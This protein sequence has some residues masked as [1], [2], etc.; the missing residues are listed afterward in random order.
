MDKP[1]TAPATPKG[2]VDPLGMARRIRL[3]T[4]PPSAPLARF[5]DYVWIVEWNMGER[6]PEIQRVLPYPNAHLVFDHGRTAIHGV[7]R[8]AFERKVAG[9]GRVLGVRFKPGGL[10]PF[11]AHPVSRLADRTMAADEVLRMSSAAAE[12]RVLEGDSDADMAG[13]AEAML[14]AVLPAPDP[15]AL[16]AEQ[17]VNAAAAIDGPASVA[18]LCAQTGIEE[19]ALQR[20]FSNYVGV[21][22]K[23]VIQRYRLQEAS[24]RLARPA[25]VDLAALASQLGF[26]DQAHFTRDFTKLVGT[27]PLEYWK[28]QQEPDQSSP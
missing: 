8:G 24:W 11:I 18:A 14:L 25:P 28:S 9:A 27:S 19:R 13:A 7:V 6:A 12:Q 4:Y 21:S 10:R 1:D 3:A 5:V 26:F 2:I 23:W 16:L 22:P 17:A 20:L 15:R